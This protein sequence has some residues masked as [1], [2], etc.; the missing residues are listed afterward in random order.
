MPGGV[1]D[2]LQPSLAATFS[3]AIPGDRCS[4]FEHYISFLIKQQSRRKKNPGFFPGAIPAG[5]KRL[6]GFFGVWFRLREPH[7]T[8]F[9]R[10]SRI[11]RLRHTPQESFASVRVTA[12]VRLITLA[13][14]EV[15]LRQGSRVTPLLCSEVTKAVTLNKGIITG[16]SRS[17]HQELIITPAAKR[18]STAALQRHQ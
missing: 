8:G 2:K 11:R 6:A 12:N 1:K 18:R 13:A 3:D 7:Q 16:R 15:F 10:H 17:A 9:R 4:K 5:M 14:M